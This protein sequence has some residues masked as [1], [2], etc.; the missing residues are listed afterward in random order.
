LE[1]VKRDLGS[2]WEHLPEGA[3]QHDH[4]AYLKATTN[5]HSKTSLTAVGA[6]S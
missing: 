3:L 6:A 1:R 2:L 4:H 5:G